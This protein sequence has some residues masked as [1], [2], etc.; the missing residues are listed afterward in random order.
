[1]SSQISLNHRHHQ[2]RIKINN[3][4]QQRVKDSKRLETSRHLDKCMDHRTN[5]N[6]FQTESN[7]TQQSSHQD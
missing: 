3:H 5:N 6:Y 7:R 4:F 1:M 2:Q